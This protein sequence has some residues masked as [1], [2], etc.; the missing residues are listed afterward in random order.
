[1]VAD[2][3]R[4][5]IL[6]VL[7]IVLTLTVLPVSSAYAE[8]KI[9]FIDVGQGDSILVQCDGE[10]MLVDAGPEEAG[11]V[12]NRYLKE[13]LEEPVLSAVIATHEHDDHLLGMADAL[14]GMSVRTVYSSRRIP[15]SWWFANILPFLNQKSLDILNPA[16][17]DSFS[18]GSVTVTFL[19]NLALA[20]NPNDLSLVV[21]IDDG[22]AS[23]LLAADI[24]GEAEISMVE[25]CVPLKA[26]ILKVA[27]HGGNTSTGDL[28]LKNVDPAWAVI[29]VGKD[30]PHGHPHTETLSKL[31]R[32][33]V[34][35]YRT[36][37]F[38]TIIAIHDGKTWSFE[39]TKAR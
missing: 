5:T 17:G 11:A 26:D 38:G 12:V 32:R 31:N 9:H 8:M 14:K 2:I 23:V 7:I 35:I 20:D 29:S 15:M 6:P 19:N 18:L 4:K 24:E 33:N 39:V 21:R 36:D 3:F 30:N 22:N 28:F 37:Q 13:N 27:H 25:G 34:T 1:M 10:A 16:F